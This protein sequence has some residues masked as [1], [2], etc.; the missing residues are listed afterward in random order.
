LRGMRKITFTPQAYNDYLLWLEIDRKLFL[1]INNLILEAAKN[2]SLGTGKPE[3]LKHELSGLWS[4]RINHE[5]RLVYS[6]TDYSVEIV[7]CRF[8][9]T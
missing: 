4:R 5:H 6:V 1:K 2:P 7:S 3:L 9:Y 8:H